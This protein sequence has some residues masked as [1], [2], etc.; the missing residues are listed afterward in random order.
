MSL[1]TLILIQESQPEVSQNFLLN[2]NERVTLKWQKAY[3][4]SDNAKKKELDES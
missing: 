3:Y 2:T 1:Q 4:R